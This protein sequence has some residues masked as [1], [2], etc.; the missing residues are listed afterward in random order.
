MKKMLAVAVL[1]AM[2]SASAAAIA[3]EATAPRE[4]SARLQAA[5]STLRDDIAAMRNEMEHMSAE[6]GGLAEKLK[7]TEHK[8]A[9]LKLQEHVTS[10]IQR[11]RAIENKMDAETGS[12]M[13]STTEDGKAANQQKPR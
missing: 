9:A 8:D 10:L 13:A 1:M 3:G 2:L 4:K 7:N 6:A 5:E 11:T 12:T